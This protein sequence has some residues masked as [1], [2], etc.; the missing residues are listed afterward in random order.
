MAVAQLIQAAQAVFSAAHPTHLHP[1]LVVVCLA[2]AQLHRPHP[3][4]QVSAAVLVS[5][6][7]RREMRQNQLV[8]S[9]AELQLAR[10]QHLP[11]LHLVDSAEQVVSSWAYL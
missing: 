7:R 2:E 4:H 9:S 3:Q 5:D 6:R 8:D 11:A 10:R 1:S